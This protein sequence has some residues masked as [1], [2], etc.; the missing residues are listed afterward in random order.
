MAVRAGE[1]DASNKLN[2]LLVRQAS[3]AWPSVTSHYGQRQ[4]FEALLTEGRTL[5]TACRLCRASQRDSRTSTKK[6][7][8]TTKRS[9]LRWARKL[10]WMKPFTKMLEWNEPFAKWFSDGELNASVNCLD[11]H[12]RAG[13]GEQ[14]R[15]LLR[16]RAGR[17]AGRSRIEQLLDDVCRF[18]NGLRKLGI[19]K[20]DR[21]AIY[22]PM[23]PEL[24]VATARHARAS[25]RR[26]R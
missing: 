1:H 15:L 20:G 24:P 4:A 10:E 19:S 16:R 22:M 25:A 2:T 21:V 26:T 5:P 6:Q 12:V 13:N 3:A 17:P 23:I 8:A 11:R 9:G 18:A 7:N 14:D